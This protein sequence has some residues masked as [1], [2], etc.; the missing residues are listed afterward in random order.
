M[1]PPPEL[2]TGVTAVKFTQLGVYDE[3]LVLC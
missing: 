2:S 1:I 3:V